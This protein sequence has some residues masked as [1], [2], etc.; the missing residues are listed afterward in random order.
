MATVGRNQE[1]PL[2]RGRKPVEHERIDARIQLWVT[3][4]FRRQMER[5]A[6]DAGYTSVS[7]Y[8]REQKLGCRVPTTPIHDPRALA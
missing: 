8:V 7:N 1:G 2:N 4:S 3:R 6:I 5:E